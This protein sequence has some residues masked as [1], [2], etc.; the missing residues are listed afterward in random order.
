M[1][2]Y[3][4]QWLENL[5]VQSSLDEAYHRECIS[6]DEYY[7]C[8]AAY[9]VK[10]YTPNFVIRIG[11][12]LLTA[13]IALFSLG[14][15]L[16]MTSSASL[17]Q[18][19][20]AVL[21]F[22]FGCIC[23]VSLEI[24]VRSYNHFKSGI[25]DAMLWMTIIYIVA[26]FNLMT[27]MSAYQNSLII[28]L[29][30]SILATRFINIAMSAIACASFIATLFF[31]YTFLGAFANATA[32]F[33]IMVASVL[34]Y[35]LFVRMEIKEQWKFHVHAFT[36]V[37]AVALITFYAAGNYFV[38]REAS[39]YLLHANYTAA[40]G[41]PLGTLFWLFTIA[42][43]FV[44]IAIGVKQKDILFLRIGLLLIAAAVFTV[45]NYYHILP[46]ELAMILAGSLMIVAGY[47]LIKYLRTPMHGF[48]D[49]DIRDKDANFK[50]Q[51]EAVVILQTFSQA[52][53]GTGN[54]TDFGGGSGGGGGVEGQF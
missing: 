12:F 25:D 23:Y 13:I 31:G 22:F 32:P 51:L 52:Q 1:I 8:L 2:A 36:A 38:V 9:P 10:F 7:N 53:T 54:K 26:G 47:V 35:L 41:I 43:P 15:I 28:F 50:K 19:G 11:L 48:S 24:T 44:Y 14:L 21:L 45:R 30:S 37:K 49:E 3:N 4:K 34:L 5:F 46:L 29:I 27:D 42:I 17:G 33:L 18:S 39:L 20:Y 40:N 6:K 16:L